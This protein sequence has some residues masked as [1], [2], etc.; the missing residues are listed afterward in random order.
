MIDNR[1]YVHNLSSG[2]IKAWKKQKNKNK[3]T[4]TERNK[5]WYLPSKAELQ[6][7]GRRLYPIQLEYRFCLSKVKAKITAN[8]N[9]KSSRTLTLAKQ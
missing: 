1:S 2:E 7:T 8:I 9:E 6:I 3:I 4:C 5:Y